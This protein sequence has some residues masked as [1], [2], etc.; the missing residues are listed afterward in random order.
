MRRLGMQLRDDLDCAVM[1][2]FQPR[3]RKELPDL[4]DSIGL[5]SAADDPALSKAKYIESRLRLVPEPDVLETL[6][7][8]LKVHGV[9]LGVAGRY[10][11]EEKL[12]KLNPP[13]RISKKHRRELAEALEG[14]P[15]FL[16]GERFLEALARI[17]VMESPMESFARAGGTQS[18]SLREG[19]AEDLG[20]KP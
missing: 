20:G 8:F 4:C 3:T 19:I 11:I 1:A 5:P 2:L 17:W 16:D 18:G 12:W 10:P 14:T 9:A 7:R 13:F 6:D 15:L